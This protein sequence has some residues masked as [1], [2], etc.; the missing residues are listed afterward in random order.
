MKDIRSIYKD[1]TAKIIPNAISVVLDQE[2]YF[3]TSFISRDKTYATVFRIWQIALADL[4]GH[5]F[6]NIFISYD[7][8]L[9]VL[10]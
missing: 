10:H 5:S 4:V 7:F 3:F 6:L 8:Y 1:K 9:N 2:K